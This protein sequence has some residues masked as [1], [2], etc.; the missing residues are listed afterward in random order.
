MGVGENDQ[1]EMIDALTLE[2]SQ[3]LAIARS[4]INERSLTVWRPDEDTI[5]LPNIN[6]NNIKI[7]IGRQ[8]RTGDNGR[9]CCPHH[10]GRFW[11][12]RKLHR[13]RWMGTV[14]RA[15]HIANEKQ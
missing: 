9:V 8:C 13:S 6:E 7:A 1:I 12:R 10:D 5:P 15:E 11:G 4:T 14:C 2:I 3:R